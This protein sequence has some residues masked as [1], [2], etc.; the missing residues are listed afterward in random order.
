MEVRNKFAAGMFCFL[1]IVTVQYAYSSA[2]DESAENASLLC[3]ILDGNDALT[4]ASEFSA[5]DRTVNISVDRSPEEAKKLCPEI[6]AIVEYHEMTFTHGWTVQITSPDS[7]Y[8]VVAI[9]PL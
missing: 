9:C 3:K 6:S 5:E 1:T 2:T 7:G 8:D 4:Q